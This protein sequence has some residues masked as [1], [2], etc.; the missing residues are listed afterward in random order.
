[1]GIGGI[2]FRPLAGGIAAL[3]VTLSAGCRTS[4]E[5]D[6]LGSQL[7]VT[8]PDP[9]EPSFVVGYRFGRWLPVDPTP[10]ARPSLEE[11]CLLEQTSQ[12]EEAIDSLGRAIESEPST[13][14]FQARGALYLSTGFPRA[15]AGDFQRAVA[16]TPEDARGWFA[17]GHA[18]EVLGLWRQAVE[19]LEHARALNGE[20]VGLFLS[21]ARVHHALAHSGQSARYYALALPRLEGRSTELLVEAAVLAT[22]DPERALAVEKMRERIEAGRGTPYS[23]EAWLLRALMR[24]LPGESADKVGATIRSLEVAPEELTTLARSLLTAIQLVDPETSGEA[25]TELLATESDAERKAAL[26]RSLMRP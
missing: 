22:E 21:L 10:S 1:M 17:L 25:R 14:L 9:A 2:S 5:V 3:A 16:L 12:E 18:Y 20:D 7:Q 26:E 11:A 6:A 4:S 23:D 8:T 15:A 19:A 24:E 13:A